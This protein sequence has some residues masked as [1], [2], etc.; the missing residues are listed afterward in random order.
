MYT[1]WRSTF[2]VLVEEL[3]KRKRTVWKRGAILMLVA[4][5]LFVGVTAAYA[6]PLQLENAQARGATSGQVWYGSNPSWGTLY[7]FKATNLSGYE[8]WGTSFCVDST[9]LNST[10][11]VWTLV[12]LS[13]E[14]EKNAARLAAMFFSGSSYSQSAFQ[15][16]I[17][18]AM[19]MRVF[20]QTQLGID[21]AALWDSDAWKGNGFGGFAIA[22]NQY[23]Q[24]QLVRVSEPATML[25]LGIGLIGL[26]ITGR[27]KFFKK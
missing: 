6:L 1:I 11:N 20:D 9:P 16:A 21:A 26:G 23:N 3:M 7:E 27:K 13:T 14:T 8:N 17:W 2:T 5:F 18:N 25:L 22:K 19:G 15:V 4:A 10:Q 12:G 24:N